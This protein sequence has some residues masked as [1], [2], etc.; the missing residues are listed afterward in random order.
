MVYDARALPAPRAVHAKIGFLLSMLPRFVRL[1]EH[2]ED[3]EKL[4]IVSDEEREKW[5]AFP[6]VLN[7]IAR[8]AQYT[9]PGY[10]PVDAGVIARSFDEMGPSTL[11]SA[12]QPLK[13]LRRRAESMLSGS[14]ESTADILQRIDSQNTIKNL[15]KE[16]SGRKK[17]KLGRPHLLKNKIAEYRKWIDGWKKS[18]EKRERY[19]NQIGITVKQLRAAQTHLR[20]ERSAKKSRHKK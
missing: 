13:E 14:D 8:Y 3:A 12:E 2:P 11:R 7:Q 1:L 9:P 19:C 17:A 18:G 10:Q 16:K 20:R 15:D 6:A 4:K 5:A